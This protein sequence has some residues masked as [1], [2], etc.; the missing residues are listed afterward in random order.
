M[1]QKMDKSSSTAIAD[2]V[3]RSLEEGAVGRRLKR[4][5][6]KWNVTK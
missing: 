6:E 1:D 3:F 2:A 4:S 5:L